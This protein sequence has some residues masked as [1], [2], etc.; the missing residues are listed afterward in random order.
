[1]RLSIIFILTLSIFIA[2]CSTK[3]QR[4]TQKIDGFSYVE[5]DL[6]YINENPE[7][8]LIGK[9]VCYSPG[10]YFLKIQHEKHYRGIRLSSTYLNGEELNTYVSEKNLSP[11][12]PFGGGLD[13]KLN[14]EQLEL[15][16][17]DNFSVK[18]FD[19][20]G[21]TVDID[22]PVAYTKEFIKRVYQADPSLENEPLTIELAEGE[23]TLNNR[24]DL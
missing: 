23:R 17:N 10:V 19:Y 21:R 16:L 13:I 18:N 7:D 5:G 20:T 22:I 4:P 9:L 11:G 8:R 14:Q 3:T 12:L 1:M 24:A 6:I 15:I 2:G